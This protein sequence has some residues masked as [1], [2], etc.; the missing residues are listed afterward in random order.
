MG[1]E[2][3]LAPLQYSPGGH[4]TGPNVGTLPMLVPIAV[5]IEGGGE[6]VKLRAC[7]ITASGIDTLAS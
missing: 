7:L 5:L 3:M 6:L 1:C 4:L 2:H